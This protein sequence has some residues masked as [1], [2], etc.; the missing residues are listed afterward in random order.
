M[1]QQIGYW[2]NLHERAKRNVYFYKME[3]ER[4]K[5]IAREQQKEIKEKEG[6]IEALKQK[7]ILLQKQLFGRKTEQTDKIDLD[8]SDDEAKDFA[9][10]NNKRSRGKQ[11]GSKGYGRRIRNN[12]PVKE[13]VHNIAIEERFCPVCG[14]PFILFPGTEDSEEIDW[15]VI[16]QRI[17]HRRKR[18][19]PTCNCTAVPGIITS[20]LDPKLI[21]KG[22]FT[23]E[24]LVR[25]LLEKFLFGTPLYRI[26]KKLELERF[27]VSGG[28]LTG[29]IKRLGE[30]LQPLYVLILEKNKSA[31]HW[32]MDETRWKVYEEIEGK[33]GYRWWLWVMVT[34][35]TCVYVVD[36]SR[37]SEI[38]R[39]H[40]GLDAEGIISADRYSAYKALGDGISVAYCWS[41]VRR[42]F[43]RIKD[44]NKK[45]SGWAIEWVKDIDELFIINRKRLE[46][47][48]TPKAFKEEDEKLREAVLKM[49][50]KRKEELKAEKMHKLKRK[51]LTSMSRHWE[52]LKIFIDQSEIPMDNN[53]AERALRN[54]VIGRKNYYGSGAVW[55]GRFT[56]MMFSIFQTLLLNRI[57]PRLYLLSY[58][59]EYAKHG[60]KVPDNLKRFFP[61]NLSKEDR[62]ILRLSEVSL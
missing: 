24:F 40:L 58:F 10:G 27:S 54:P 52:G 21:P 30:F 35:D 33:K 38:P 34:H 32:H 44:G 11:P 47:R 61:W 49:E 14:K 5:R 55:S 28:T 36:P 57:D 51:V 62:A 19:K 7:V 18:Y 41:H 12:L 22:M 8:N 26:R 29:N 9:Q 59:D 13:I 53:E 23:N 56:A 6:Q 25:L 2:K 3:A 48:G 60:G 37:S 16:V 15:K 43:L 42:D 45:L 20:P 46:V 31:R 50:Q 17:V 39:N 4:Y 1:L